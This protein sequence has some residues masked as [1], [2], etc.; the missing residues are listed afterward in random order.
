MEVFIESFVSIFECVIFISFITLFL[1]SNYD[2]KKKYLL[3]A[4]FLIIDIIVVITKDFNYINDYILGCIYFLYYLT[5]S[6]TCLKGCM[7]KKIFVS[8]FPL[9]LAILINSIVPYAV[10]LITKT[11]IYDMVNNFSF[12]RIFTLFL[13][14]FALLLMCILILKVQKQF[15][16]ELS[17][18]QYNYLSI[19]QI[20]S[21]ALTIVIIENTNSTLGN[22]FNQILYT[23]ACAGIVICNILAYALMNR[24]NQLNLEKENNLLLTQ[25]NDYQNTY[26]SNAI[27]IHEKSRALK[28]DLKN[29]LETINTLVKN[30]EN[31]KV[32]EYIKQFI[33][34]N[35]NSLII[36]VNSGNSAIDAVLGN[37]MTACKNLGIH[38][39]YNI[40]T[41]LN[42]VPSLDVC[43]ILA[44]ALD[45]AIEANGIIDEPTIELHMSR[46]KN[47][48]HIL[49]TNKINKSVFKANPNLITT[50]EDSDVHGIG[51]KSIQASVAKL[52]GSVN[53]DE[54][55]NMFI[56]DILVPVFTD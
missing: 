49:L 34:D 30:N 4:L 8:I 27:N 12:L 28:H 37:K 48:L 22:Q 20:V 17:S 13:T 39:I 1:G 3:F 19:I 26:V 42:N 11:S 18:I 38:F 47:F 29:H 44:N 50:K 43:T 46:N 14:K 56:C 15:S 5:Y 53:F 52:G 31:E 54:K 21:Y 10:S 6:I 24:I 16:Q 2:T 51:I 35:I 41:N 25:Q 45:N 40:S 7:S 36:M 9:L 32:H 55:E 33:N 23:S